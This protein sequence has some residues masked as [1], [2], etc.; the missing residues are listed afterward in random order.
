MTDYEDLYESY[1]KE[2][3]EN[4][5]GTLNLDA[6]KRELFDFHFVMSEV[7]KVYD[8]ITGGGLS[9]A[10]YYASGVISLAEEVVAQR[11]NWAI[12]DFID[13]HDL[14]QGLKEELSDD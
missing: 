1:W 12:E 6:V 4:P 14:P 5:D 13:D 9:K 10:N 11:I 7:P 3:V 8:H 2:L